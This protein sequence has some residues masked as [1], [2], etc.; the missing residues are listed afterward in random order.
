MIKTG[1]SLKRKLSVIVYVPKTE[2]GKGVVIFNAG[3]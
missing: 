1:Q 2:R 3:Y